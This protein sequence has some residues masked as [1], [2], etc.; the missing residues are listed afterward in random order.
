VGGIREIHFYKTDMGRCPVVDYIEAIRWRAERAKITKVFETVQRMQMVPTSFL[1]K[2]KGRH[3][4]WEIRV[5]SFRFLGF[6]ADSRKLV[7][8]HAF[9][10]KSRKTPEQ[11]IAVAV[12]RIK[13][14]HGQLRLL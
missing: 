8:V 9:D 13:A 12:E 4:L 11:A 10:K 3:G 1:K 5:R 6:Y 14:Y 2:L 7:L